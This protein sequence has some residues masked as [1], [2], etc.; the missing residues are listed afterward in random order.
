MKN[1]WL[2]RISHEARYSYPLLEDNILTIGFSDFS[3]EENISSILNDD[4]DEIFKRLCKEA[5]WEYCP[6]SVFSLKKFLMMKKEDWVIIPL[7]YGKF[8]IYEIIDDFGQCIKN[9]Q[10]NNIRDWNGN[11]AH[12]KDNLIYSDFEK[13]YIDLGFFRKV[14]LIENCKEISRSGYADKELIRRLKARQTTLNITDLSE[15]IESVV[16]RLSE[17]KPL[18]FY[19][20]YMQKSRESI[21]EII[22]SSVNTEEKFEL[23][24]KCYFEALGAEVEIPSKNSPNKPERADADII[25][26]FESTK[27]IYYV[28][29]KYHN[30]G[31]LTDDWAVSQIKEYVSYKDETDSNYSRISWVISFASDYT[32]EARNLAAENNIILINRY[33]FAGMLLDAGIKIFKNL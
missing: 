22:E 5:E 18:S 6:K 19:S 27:T 11:F 28:Q 29:A 17:N 10:I 2:H 7:F 33:E 9:L 1:F 13:G 15:N 25:A 21:I 8:G 26:V 23:L 3:K 14:K 24:I 16:K 4:S 12:I 30:N 32:K 20:D 31:T